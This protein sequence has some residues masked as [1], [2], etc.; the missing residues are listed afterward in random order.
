VARDLALE[1]T[2]VAEAPS[3]AR[4]LLDLP[5]L[6]LLQSWDDTESAGW[7]RMVL[8]DQKVP[9]TLIMDEDVRKGGL[10]GRFDVIVFPNTYASLPDMVG[11]MDPRHGPLAYT[12]TPEFPSHGT[13][14]SSPDITGG[15]T[16]AG[17]GHLEQFVR[18]G[19]LLVT[20]GGASRLP[21]DGG[22]VRDVRRARVTGVST[23]GSELR[24]RFRRPD[25]PIAYGYKELT[26]AFREDLPL[27]A[28]RRA[29]R[30]RVVLQWGTTLPKDDD[31]EST[32]GDK[33]E[34]KDA[35][36][37]SGGIKGA[38][39]VE[40]KPAI[41]DLPTGQGRVVAFDFD[42]IHRY[43]TQSDFRLVWNAILNWNDLPAR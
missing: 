12:K 38:S 39:E 19:G 8:D 13:P 37:V 20:L 9:Y 11:G 35:L 31:A 4:H 32:D 15:F 14:T 1:V 22:I 2:A 25:H 28:V 6:A 30:A 21:L 5:R 3:V 27:Y 43:Q 41:L 23:P 10:R 26:S 29:D 24:A 17:V 42:P 16:W 36:V 33:D 7:L 40:G 18:S 34:K